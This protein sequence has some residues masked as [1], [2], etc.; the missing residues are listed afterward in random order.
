MKVCIYTLG[1]KVNTY[2]SEYMMNLF[3][4]NGYTLSSFDEIC[5]IY[6]VNSCS[7]TNTADTKTRKIIREC[8]RKN[9]NAVI[10]VV[11]C[12]IQNHHQD[13]QD[14]IDIM[15]G[16]KDKSKIVSYVEEYL[17]NKQK[18]KQIYNMQQQEFEAM[19]ITSF[20]TKTRAF[21]K[22]QDGCN[23]YCSYCIIPYVRGNL[24]YKE[25][26][27]VIKEVS[28]LVEKGYKE[29]VLTGIH[30]GSYG[31]SEYRFVDLLKDL[32]KIDGL[33]RLRISSIEITEINDEIIELLKNSNII[34]N[35]LH[36]PLQSGSNN[37]LRA[38]NRKYDLDYYEHIINKI[39]SVRPD[40]AI[41]TDIIVGFPGESDEDFNNTLAFVKKINFSFVHVFPYSKR[42]GTV[43]SKMD[44]QIDV[45]IKKM[46][47]RELGN[48]AKCQDRE[49]CYNFLNKEIEVLT[50][51]YHD[52]YVVGHTSNYLK[53]KFK[54]DQSDINKIYKVKINDIDYPYCI[55]TKL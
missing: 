17:K 53:V 31:N 16:N 32:I 38:M 10:A 11:G 49:Y 20:P 5:D 27:L 44:N 39:R 47:A 33:Y 34:A 42:D 35:H 12:Y 21:V 8:R 2:E 24:R 3:Q 36:I 7:V 18:I 52:G 6:V 40:I 37:I 41:T 15:L 45:P 4:E 9:N 14:D 46:R 29:V 51:V 22:I 48:L 50:E 1:C 30:T 25:K 54:G 28:N 23:N 43:A 19:E 13:L 55:G 26:D